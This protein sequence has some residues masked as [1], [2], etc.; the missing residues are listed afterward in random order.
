MRR[1][2][3]ACLAAVCLS[4]G[5]HAEEGASGVP[6]AADSVAEQILALQKRVEALEA[7][8]AFHQPIQPPAAGFLDPTTMIRRIGRAPGAVVVE[9]KVPVAIAPASAPLL[10][11][12]AEAGNSGPASATESGAAQSLGGPAGPAEVS[13]V[14]NVFR[15]AKPEMLMLLSHDGKRLRPLCDVPSHPSIGSPAVSPAG[16]LIAFD[17]SRPGTGLE[18]TELLMVKAD[19]TGL[20]CLGGGAMPS[21]S[22]DGKRLAFSSYAPR[23]VYVLDLATKK[24]ELIDKEGWGIQWSPD[25]TSWAYSRGGSL[26]VKNVATGQVYKQDSTLR[27]IQPYWGWNM[28]WS[29]D[30]LSMCGVVELAN[31]QTAMVVQPLQPFP[32]PEK[33]TGRVGVGLRIFNVG[34][35][36]NKDVAW[37]PSGKRVVFT[38]FSTAIG[39]SQLFEFDPTRNSI[40]SPVAGQTPT[41]NR[42][43]CWSADGKTLV[44]VAHFNIGKNELD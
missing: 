35:N 5:V 31:G 12:V 37:H 16:D 10:S 17:G 9:E 34:G 14:S 11:Q 25:G 38:A 13:G 32:E 26:I 6:A 2:V 29:P 33:G 36:T 19:G 44:Y 20:E 15:M 41:N 4:S 18:G 40:P 8:P 27:D 23:G 43:Q 22:A 30:S 24:R 3:L 1:T 39:R 21:W 42:D 7:R 28:A